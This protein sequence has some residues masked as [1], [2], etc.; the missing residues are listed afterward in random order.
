MQLKS[1]VFGSVFAV[2][3][4]FSVGAR[5]DMYVFGGS[6]TGSR[7]LILNGTIT[8]DAVN[9]GWYDSFG[10]HTANNANY[11]AGTIGTSVF[12]DYFVFDLSNVT[13]PIT[14]ATLS[15]S[16]PPTGYADSNSSTSTAIYDNWQVGTPIATLESD[17]SGATG[18]YTDLADGSLYGSTTVGYADNGPGSGLQVNIVLSSLALSDLNASEG[19]QFAVGGSLTAA[20]PEPSTWAMMILGFAGIGFMAYRRKSKPALMTA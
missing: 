1:L 9:S 2:A 14:S 8:L 13:T 3:S 19:S 7:Q 15:I 18:I 17:Q 5:A 12:H 4:F 6:G 10:D 20:V 11:L 16:N